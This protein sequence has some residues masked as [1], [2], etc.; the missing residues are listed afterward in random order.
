MTRVVPSHPQHYPDRLLPHRLQEYVF[1]DG[2]P[3]TTSRAA[4]HMVTGREILDIVVAVQKNLGLALIDPR[5]Y[6]GTCFHEAGCSNEWDTEI[7]SQSCIG[8]FV[9]VGAYQ[10]GEE[11]ARKYGF[12]LEDMLDLEKATICMVKLAEDNR[13]RL[14]IFAKLTNGEP[15]PDYVDEHGTLWKGGSMRAMLAIAHNHGLG[16]ASRYLSSNSMDYAVFRRRYANDNIVS[17]KYGDDCITG[18][19]NYPLDADPVPQFS[20]MRTLLLAD[21]HMH[22]EDVKTLQA[23]L[24]VAADGDFGPKT[25]KALRQFQRE[26]GLSDDGACGPKTWKIVLAP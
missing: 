17:H 16:W 5:Y 13:K 9:S 20:G 14:R 22:G 6:V 15:D 3:P 21:P 10:I 11:E 8:G 23:K 1:D 26:H 18:G 2:R 7:A 19:P 12:E 24:G 4:A 25:D